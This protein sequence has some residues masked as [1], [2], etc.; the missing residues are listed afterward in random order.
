MSIVEKTSISKTGNEHDNEDA[1]V[2]TD[3]F[4]SVIDGMTPKD[5][6]LYQNESPARIAVKRIA[7]EIQSFP[8]DLNVQEASKRLTQCIR[9]YYIEKNI[10]NEV[11]EHPYKRMSASA[12]ILSKAR[13]EIWMFG[14]CHCLIDGQHVTNEKAIDHF[15]SEMRSQLIKKY[16]QIHSVEELL[17]YDK[18][19]EDIEPFLKSQYLYQN[20]RSNSLLSYS[21]IDGFSIQNEMIKVASFKSGSTVILAS[22]GYPILKESLEETEAELQTL[23]KN[24][25]LMYIL[26]K[27]TKGL[28]RGNVSFDDR[29]YIKIMG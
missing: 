9:N 4:I 19:R 27:S 13:Q 2:I 8:D 11:T 28:K 3:S 15:L 12:I 20:N 6:S 10:L 5:F 22:D 24:D 23:L 26:I 21:V 17:A 14:D 18:A 16:R 29:T 1:M 25:P 7:N